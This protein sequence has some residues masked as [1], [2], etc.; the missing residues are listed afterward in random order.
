MMTMPS[1]IN[2]RRYGDPLGT[3]LVTMLESGSVDP[4]T[5]GDAER[6]A[7]LLGISRGHTLKLL[8][9]LTAAGRLTRLKKGLY[10]LNNPATKQPRAHPFA[11]GTALVTPSAVS[12]WS[13]LQH[14]GMTEQI[15]GTVTLS[16]PRRTY[17]PSGDTT[18]PGEH[19]AWLVAGARYQVVSVVTA[20]FFGITDVWIDE[21]SRVPVFDRERALLDAFQH[22]HIFGSLSAGLS[23]LD[24]HLTELDLN[25]LARYALRLE[26]TAVIKRVGWSLAR[27]HVPREAL[28]PLLAYP[29]KGDTPLDPGR[30]P[31]GRHDPVWRIIENMGA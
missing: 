3:Q 15:P 8:T 11:I 4:F 22:F 14:W 29:A 10:A 21:R 5:S 1:H 25:L 13:A 17:P 24:E 7:A 9:Q 19:R 16:S 23:I 26:V 31:H 12:H 18:P 6:E 27:L 2:P 20:K 30:P 28:E